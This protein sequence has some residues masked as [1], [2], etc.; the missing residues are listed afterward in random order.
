[1]VLQD[2]DPLGP[3]PEPALLDAA[4]ALVGRHQARERAPVVIGLRDAGTLVVRGLPGDARGV[5]RSLVT[6]AAVFHP[7]DDLGIAVLAEDEPTAQAWDWIKWLPHTR[8]ATAAAGRGRD[9]QPEVAVAAAQAG[10]LLHLLSAAGR[11]EGGRHLLLVVDGWSPA[12]ALARLAGLPAL[13]SGGQ[14]GLTVLCCVA[15]AADEPGELRTRLALDAGGGAVAEVPGETVSRAPRFAAEP[16]GEAEALAI[17]RRLTPLRVAPREGEEAPRGAGASTSSLLDALGLG[18][19]SSIDLDLSWRRAE[20]S[21]LRAPVGVDAGGEQV[22]LDL[23][24]VAQGGMG[25]HGMLIGATGSGKSELLRT[26]VAGLAATH[27]PDHGGA[28]PPRGGG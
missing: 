8:L 26:L 15:S 4:R 12:A 23:K 21:L 2:V 11:E 1:V 17:A 18:P 25:P 24:E 13:L 7:P 20:V 9:H 16:L 3:A 28:L 10:D 19:P 14:S 5:A 27:P 6:Q 22:E